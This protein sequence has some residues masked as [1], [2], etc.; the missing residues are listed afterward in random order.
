MPDPIIRLNDDGTLDEFV[1]T[2][3]IHFEAMDDSQWWI[4][5]DLPDGRT[6][7]I[8]CGAVNQRAKGY[9]YVEE[10]SGEGKPE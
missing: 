3:T 1:A 10:D 2:G 6:F 7:H 5:V 8:R 4:G 9:A